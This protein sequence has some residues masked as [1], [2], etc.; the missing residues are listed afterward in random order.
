VRNA[1]VYVVADEL[2]GAA[3]V[4]SILLVR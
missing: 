2:G 3:T 4:G 1:A